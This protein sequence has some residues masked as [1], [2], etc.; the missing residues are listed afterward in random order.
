MKNGI[1]LRKELPE[2]AQEAVGTHYFVKKTLPAETK[3]SPRRSQGRVLI[4]TLPLTSLCMDS[5]KGP[6]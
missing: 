1:S 6:H 3:P 5:E 2:T 4:L